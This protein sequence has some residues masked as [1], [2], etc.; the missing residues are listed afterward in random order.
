MTFL[1][2]VFQSV[3][4][5]PQTNRA[6]GIDISKYDKFF[7]PETAT[8]QLDFVIQRISYGIRQDEAF[9]DLV[10]GVMRVPIRGGYH[11]L[12]SGG[13]WKQQADL[14][15]ERVKDKPY[16]FFA[17]DFEGAFNRMSSA[18]AYEAWRW[19]Q[20]VA[21]NSKKKVVLYT[22]PSN[23]VSYIAPSEKEYGIDWNSVDLWLAQYY[24][25]PDPNKSPSLPKNRT[26]WSLWQ[27]TDNGN[28]TQYG[29]ARPTACD[30]NVYDGTKEQM[31]RWLKISAPPDPA[32]PPEPKS[33][34]K[35][36][37]HKD[38]TYTITE[39]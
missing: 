35:I 28:G 12:S 36:E 15:L 1:H 32:E 3:S 9:G 6:H 25:T 26:Q 22:N 21:S 33:T 16:H 23:Y 27:Y 20:Y 4:N 11:Y 37:I 7:N 24:F 5:I 10:D 13:N 39:L 19:T 30:L 14:F 2:S 18:F 17:C 34:I 29:V 38:A 31:G 8:A